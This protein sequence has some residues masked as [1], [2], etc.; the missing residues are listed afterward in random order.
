MLSTVLT[1]Q[2]LPLAWTDTA[3]PGDQELSTSYSQ[4]VIVAQIPKCPIYLTVQLNVARSFLNK[5]CQQSI[6]LGIYVVFGFK[7]LACDQPPCFGVWRLGCFI[8]VFPLDTGISEERQQGRVEG[9]ICVGGW[10]SCVSILTLGCRGARVKVQLL[11]IA[12][13]Y[14]PC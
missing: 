5:F 7:L 14:E 13:E 2:I 12:L 9:R 1:E 11:R 6:M 4:S 3:S 10:G 8:C